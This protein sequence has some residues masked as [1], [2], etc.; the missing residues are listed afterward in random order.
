[1]IRCIASRAIGDASKKLAKVGLSGNGSVK[2]A[3]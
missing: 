3:H 2:H 1:M